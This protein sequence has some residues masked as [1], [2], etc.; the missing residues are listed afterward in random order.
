MLCQSLF[1]YIHNLSK[2]SNKNFVVNLILAGYL[3]RKI[4]SLKKNYEVV[5]N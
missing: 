2:F 4:L 3:L 1:A 5:Q